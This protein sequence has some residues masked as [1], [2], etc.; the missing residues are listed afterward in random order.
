MTGSAFSVESLASMLFGKGSCLRPLAGRNRQRAAMLAAMMLVA[1]MVYV[2]MYPFEVHNYCLC[3][4]H[5]AGFLYKTPSP[6]VKL[7]SVTH[8]GDSWK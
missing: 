4:S 1:A 8:R 3:I 7:V 6:L 5:E 2:A